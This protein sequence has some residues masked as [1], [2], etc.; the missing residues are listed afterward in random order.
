[1]TQSPNR[2]SK[3][4]QELKRRKVIK[5]IGMYAAT[6]FIL[7]EV[8]DIITPALLLPSWTVTLVI[9]LL[10]LG[11]PIAII[12]SWIFDFTP[13]GIKKTES[14]EEAK[15]QEPTSL[16]A[17]RGIKLSDVIIAA[18]FVTVC[19][20]LYPKI[21]KSDKFEQIRDELDFNSGL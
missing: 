6:A 10:A 4:W 16:L 7:L 8:V 12:L 13:E 15:K 18:L 19:V 9:V 21:F 5:V 20:L 1:M 17:K 11:F 3:F 2:L 14:I